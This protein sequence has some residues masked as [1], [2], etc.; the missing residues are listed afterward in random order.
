M[1]DM[2]YPYDIMSLGGFGDVIITQTTAEGILLVKNTTLRPSQGSVPNTIIKFVGGGTGFLV[3]VCDSIKTL[4]YKV[5]GLVITAAHVVCDYKKLDPKA[6]YFKCKIQNN[7]CKAYLIKSYVKTYTDEIEAITLP[8]K[9]CLPGDIALLLLVSKNYWQVGYYKIDTNVILSSECFISGFPRKP[10]NLDYCFPQSNDSSYTESK[11]MEAFKRFKS[12]V[13]SEGKISNMNTNLIEIQ[14]STTSG[15]SGSPV[16]SNGKIVGVYVGGP[17]LPGQRELYLIILKINST[18]DE[19]EISEF[20]DLLKYDQ[21]YNNTPFEALASSQ[22]LANYINFYSLINGSNNSNPNYILLK[23]NFRNIKNFLSEDLYKLIYNLII[24]YKDSD[25]LSF[26]IA[27]SIKHPLFV[28]IEKKI[29]EFNSLNGKYISPYEV[30]QILNN[31][32]IGKIRIVYREIFS[33]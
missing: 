21:Y 22:N 17:P 32:I 24:L 9:Y 27:I 33:K 4:K 28:D 12:L 1:G 11:V 31:S 8:N 19:I 6:R 7:S 10:H 18:I 14:C 30:T 5:L 23:K 20:Q 15:M 3:S 13:Y 29:K 26:N 16:I 2:M 25:Q